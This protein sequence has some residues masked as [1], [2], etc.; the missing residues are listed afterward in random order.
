MREFARGSVNPAIERCTRGPAS[1]VSV[2]MVGATGFEPA[3]SFYLL[4]GTARNRSERLS[5]R[6]GTFQESRTVVLVDAR[7]D[8]QSIGVFGGSGA[9]PVLPRIRVIVGHG[10]FLGSSATTSFSLRFS[11]QSFLISALLSSRSPWTRRGDP[12]SCRQVAGMMKKTDA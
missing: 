3:T 5:Q 1:E 12:H 11:A 4:L 9:P 7:N 2:E 8:P 10:L 6:L